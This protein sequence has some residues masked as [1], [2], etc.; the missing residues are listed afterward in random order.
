VILHCGFPSPATDY[1]QKRI[2]LVKELVP[3][4]DYSEYVYTTGDCCVDR[5]VFEGSV[6][7][8]D[9]SE[10]PRKGDLVYLRDS[11]G[12]TIRVYCIEGGQ[13]VFRA[14][15]KARAYK[16]IL[17][18]DESVELRG[19]VIKIIIDPRNKKLK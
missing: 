2:D 10:T 6:V 18:T 15:N 17:L 19:V 14:A 13:V 16:P 8:V 5:G 7:I 4:P 1:V 12:D 11:E 9:F 3:H